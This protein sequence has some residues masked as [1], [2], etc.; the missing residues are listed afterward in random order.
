MS[1]REDTMGT[2]TEAQNEVAAIRAGWGA[3]SDPWACSCR[4]SGWVLTQTD[5]FV[6]CP[7]HRGLRHPDDHESV[8]RT[9]LCVEATYES[10]ATCSWW[11]EE[12]D[13]EAATLKARAL[14]DDRGL[15]TR[16]FRRYYVT[17]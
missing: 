16:L 11:F 13:L 4:G 8:A 3:S 2:M 7:L 17:R 10:G 5:V 14:R 1:A 15:P 12:E 9:R 6:E